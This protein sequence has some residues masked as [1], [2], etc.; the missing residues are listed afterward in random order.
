MR[1]NLVPVMR[2]RYALRAIGDLGSENDTAGFELP[3]PCGL[4]TTDCYSATSWV[5]HQEGDNCVRRSRLLR[6][7]VQRDKVDV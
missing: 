7:L 2:L 4:K 6:V 1:V 5:Q 3:I